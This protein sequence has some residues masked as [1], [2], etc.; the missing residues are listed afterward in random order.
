MGVGK[1]LRVYEVNNSIT[2]PLIPDK[3]IITKN[4]VLKILRV[5]HELMLGEHDGW[6]EVFDIETSSITHSHLFTEG[7]HIN[8]IIAI[9][10][11]HY[12]LAALEGLLKITRDELINHY[13]KG[14]MV[15]S[16]CHIYD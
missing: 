11:T 12:L 7:S 8:D 16:V 13:H 9:D 4:K 6:L 3:M 15:T 14:K 1:K 10:D 2:Q 5:G